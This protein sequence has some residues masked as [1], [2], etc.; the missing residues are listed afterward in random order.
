MHTC[1][2]RGFAALC[3][4][5]PAQGCFSQN[6]DRAKRGRDPGCNLGSSATIRSERVQE[7]TM[8]VTSNKAKSNL[9]GAAFPAP[10]AGD[11]RVE[12]GPT[13]PAAPSLGGLSNPP[14]GAQHRWRQ[15]TRA[16]RW[17]QT[18]HRSQRHTLSPRPPRSGQSSSS[19]APRAAP[20]GPL[21]RNKVQ[22]WARI[23]STVFE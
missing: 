7:L 12:W 2:G 11:G 5:L 20:V 10:C 17:S 22:M 4:T 1:R 6:W 19:S 9:I 15:Q 18:Q 14:K 16:L 13:C 8:C 21:K 23:S 3:S